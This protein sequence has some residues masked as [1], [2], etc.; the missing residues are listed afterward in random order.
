MQHCRSPLCRQ[1]GR[2]FNHRHQR[3]TVTTTTGTTVPKNASATILSCFSTGFPGFFSSKPPLGKFTFGGDPD[4]R[5]AGE[6]ERTG[7][8]YERVLSE[9]RRRKDLGIADS[10]KWTEEKILGARGCV[11]ND[12]PSERV[13][14]SRYFYTQ[15]QMK[16]STIVSSFGI[17]IK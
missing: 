8:R 14:W 13:H 9:L 10:D 16:K 12:R 11:S 1:L 2:S 7:G 17:N 4:P 15:T 3:I 6:L 5:A